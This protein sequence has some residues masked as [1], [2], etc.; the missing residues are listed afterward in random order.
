MEYSIQQNRSGLFCQHNVFEML[1][2]CFS[3]SLLVAN[4]PFFDHT[5]VYSSILLVLM[6]NSTRCW[7]FSKE[8]LLELRRKKGGE[9]MLG[10]RRWGIN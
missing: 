1:V 2:V 6:A 9:N 7:T 10:G 3:S 8:G 5:T 4:S